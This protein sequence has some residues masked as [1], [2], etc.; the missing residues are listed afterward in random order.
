[1]I[2]HPPVD[3]SGLSTEEIAEAL[4]ELCDPQEVRDKLV[5][6]TL[7]NVSRS[8]FR[9]IDQMRLSRLGAEA[10]YLKVRPEFDDEK[11]DRM[12]RPADRFSLR[13]EF[14]S[15]LSQEAQEGRIADAIRREVA[16]YGSAVLDKA[17]AAKNTE[18]LDAPQ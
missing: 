12:E 1:M 9:R 17:V 5:R 4:M 7:R 14:V 6:I 18:V 3:C 15:Y 16:D 8:A 2:D 13:Q 11:E 10:I